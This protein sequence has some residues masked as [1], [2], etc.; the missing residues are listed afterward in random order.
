MTNAVSKPIAE[1]PNCGDLLGPPPVIGGED[2]KE[3]AEL[4]ERIQGDAKPRGFIER[5]LVR[6]VA[7]HI[8]QLRRSRRLKAAL[9]K[10][11][12]YLG[13]EKV[14]QPL[15]GWP[16]SGE[17]AKKWAQRDPDTLKQVDALL[18]KASLGVDAVM[19]ETF[20]LNLRVI[21]SFDSMIARDEKHYASALHEIERHREA[22]ADAVQATKEAED[23]E[24]EDILP[25]DTANGA[26][27]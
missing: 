17:V 23:A 12:A 9:L 11:T 26:A 22:L 5:A 1:A 7:D 19:A 4:L 18:A 21:D 3:Y 24:F 20:S 2:P 8:W 25:K 13:L 6:D 10:V 27:P 14:L 16:E 15:V